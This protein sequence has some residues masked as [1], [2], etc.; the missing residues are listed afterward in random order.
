MILS[1]LLT[2]F[3]TNSLTGE[4]EIFRTDGDGHVFVVTDYLLLKSK[5]CILRAIVCLTC[6][7]PVV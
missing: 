4:L 2:L 1:K 3:V 7:V 6:R 5:I